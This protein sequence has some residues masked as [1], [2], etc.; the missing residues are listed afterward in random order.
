MLRLTHE[1]A[2]MRPLRDCDSLQ[3]TPGRTI[4]IPF[5]LEYHEHSSFLLPSFGIFNSVQNSLAALFYR[6]YITAWFELLSLDFN[7][8]DVLRVYAQTIDDRGIVLLHV[9][10]KEKTLDYFVKAFAKMIASNR[11]YL[12]MGIDFAGAPAAGGEEEAEA[13]EE[14]DAPTKPKRPRTLT[15]RELRIQKDTIAATRL[16]HRDAAVFPAGHLAKLEFT[17]ESH[18]WFRFINRKQ[19]LDLAAIFGAMATALGAERVRFVDRV[20]NETDDPLAAMELAP[21]QTEWRDAQVEYGKTVEVNGKEITCSL[22]NLLDPT[23]PIWAALGLKNEALLLA[24]RNTIKVLRHASKTLANLAQY[25]MPFVG[26]PEWRNW[27][28]YIGGLVS[29]GNDKPSHLLTFIDFSR[30]QFASGS[31]DRARMANVIFSL[32]LTDRDI[33]TSISRAA[34]EFMSNERRGPL[35]IDA[36]SMDLNRYSNLTYGQNAHLFLL[37]HFESK[38]NIYKWHQQLSLVTLVMLGTSFREDEASMQLAHL[39]Q[40]GVRGTGKSFLFEAAKKYIFPE[41]LLLIKTHESQMNRF[42]ETAYGD[43]ADH[44]CDVADELDPAIVNAEGVN[45]GLESKSGQMVKQRL[46][47]DKVQ[48]VVLVINADGKREQVKF[49]AAVN[50]SPLVGNTNADLT[51]ADPATVSRLVISSFLPI[52]KVGDITHSKQNPAL[53]KRIT[54]LTN[55]LSIMQKAGVIAFPDLSGLPCFVSR[56]KARLRDNP[57]VFTSYD[58]AFDRKAGAMATLLS[59]HMNLTAVLNVFL[60][61]ALGTFKPEQLLLCNRFLVPSERDIVLVASHMKSDFCSEIIRAVGRACVQI[62]RKDFKKFV[63]FGI[64][65]AEAARDKRATA[66]GK[67]PWNTESFI[68]SEL[69]SL[70]CIEGNADKD[71][72]P[73]L[74]FASSNG[75]SQYVKLLSVQGGSANAPEFIVLDRFAKKLKMIAGWPETDGMSG[76]WII[77]VISKLLTHNIHDDYSIVGTKVMDCLKEPHAAMKIDSKAIGMSGNVASLWVSR[78]LLNECVL[79]RNTFR[80]ALEL[81]VASAGNCEAGVY[82]T[83]EPMAIEDCEDAWLKEYT[84]KMNR[85][86]IPFLSKFFKIADH[87]TSCRHYE[88]D[89]ETQFS[90]KYATCAATCFRRKHVGKVEKVDITSMTT[91]EYILSRK[92]GAHEGVI[93]EALWQSGFLP[94]EDGDSTR[95]YPEAAMRETIDNLKH[96]PVA[97]GVAAD[98]RKLLQARRKRA[99]EAQEAARPM[100]M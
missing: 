19:K 88:G 60:D 8:S 97:E 30:S 56:L 84:R 98:A 42:V 57:F 66:S 20:A 96:P 68:I 59:A 18:N 55:V 17:Y 45:K 65:E 7:A 29:T 52:T 5:A 35:A 25:A 22:T 99:R 41:D 93:P 36:G 32:I 27:S 16:L 9:T 4:I 33:P 14:E 21:L 23:S 90:G 49:V 67:L 10:F 39:A 62:V 76:G 40:L 83:A 54:F 72:D 48:S 26:M 2:S 82:I 79:E 50:H 15:K 37:R 31:P 12:N 38:L 1:Q 63:L 71:I 80:G 85:P 28:S 73:L 6:A 75:W 77:N 47:V 78:C 86:M 92:L 64:S 3:L 89:F 53:L 70:S 46:T 69:S 81:A 34:S 24:P 11:E 44:A 94:N 95:L 51:N 91:A 13:N 43:S 87:S 61:P 74:E 58:D 100:Q